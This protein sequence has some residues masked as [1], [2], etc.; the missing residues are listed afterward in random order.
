MLT[1]AEPAVKLE[2]P[3]LSERGAVWVAHAADSRSVHALMNTHNLAEIIAR[4]IVARGVAVDTAA[5]FINPTLRDLLPDPMHLIDMQ[6]AA[7]R[8]AKAIIHAEKIMILGDY[9]VD[10]A[11]SSALLRRFFAMVGHQHT[12]VYIPDRMR[13][14]YGPSERLMERFANEGQQVVITVDCGTLAFAA[15]KKAKELGVDVIVLD[16][17][18]SDVLLP[19][20]CA[21]VNPNRIDETSEIR[22][23]AAVGMAFLCAVAVRSLL[24]TAGYFADKASP[25]LMQLLDL[26]ALGTVCDVVPLIGIN[27]AFVAQG[28]K[29]MAQRNNQGLVALAEFAGVREGLTTYHLGYI[30]GPRVNAGGRVGESFLGT[31]LLTTESR[32][33]AVAIAAKLEN[34]NNERKAIEALVLDEAMAMAEAMPEDAPALVLAG[35]GWHQGVIGIVAGRV[36]ERFHKPTAV[37]ALDNGVGK[38]S[39]RSISGFDFGQTVIAATQAGL[40]ISGGG[41]KMAAGFSIASEQVIPFTEYVQQEVL[42]QFANQLPMRRYYFDGYLAPEGINLELALQIEALGPFGSGMAEPTF[43]ISAMQP[44]KIMPCGTSAARLIFAHAGVMEASAT[45][46]V[47][48]FGVRGTP[49]EEFIDRA[50]LLRRP[51]DLLVKLRVNRWQGRQS[52]DLHLEDMRTHCPT[53]W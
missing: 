49:S 32:E 22:Y 41:H 28:L 33:E 11:T 53:A 52:V 7:E 34:F 18:Q 20:A 5:S 9:D 25:N 46:Q 10:G 2:L 37:I 27:R 26:V 14:G 51:L 31:E 16:H 43:L 30:L 39:A 3:P 36:K 48:A 17:H 8:I 29:V 47:L 45:I 38:A 40:L 23:V 44:I 35:E 15:L 12:S 1:S 6:K 21:I 19:E 13:D 42:R 24:E 4:I 50:L